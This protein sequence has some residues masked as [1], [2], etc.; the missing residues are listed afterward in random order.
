MEKMKVKPKDQMNQ[1]H[2]LE[3]INPHTAGIDIGSQFHYVCVGAD[4]DAQPIRKF[5]CFT[6]ELHKLADWL[7]A[8]KITTVAMESTGVYWIPVFQ[9]L[10][11][12]GLHVILVNARHVKNV[13]GKKTD[14]KDC[15][16]LQQLHSYGLLSGSFRPNADI[17]VLRSYVR[18]RENLIRN[19]AAH[20][21]R[22]QKA[23]TQMNLQLHKVISDITGATGIAIIKAI[24]DGERDPKVLASLKN[25]QIK[26]DEEVIANALV[27][28]Y[29]EE[30]LFSLKQEYD[31][32]CFY[33]L[34]ITECD[35]QI[36]SF[37]QNATAKIDLTEKPLAKRKSKGRTSHPKFDLRQE[38]YRIIGTD[39]TA[40]PGFDV[41][42]VQSIVSEV[43]LDMTKWPTEK[44]FASWLGLSPGNKIS[45]DKV[46][47]SKTRKVI[48]RATV[49]FRM[50]AYAAG[51][52]HTALGAYYRRLKSR[53][54][55]PKAITATA[56]KLACLC[57]RL[58][59]F[60]NAYIE[61]GIDYYE[62]RYK[63]RVIK[64]LTNRAKELGYK[65][66]ENTT[67]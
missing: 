62:T 50:A 59:R 30:H 9:V 4:K 37:Y 58:L 3:M 25:K 18:Q 46:L 57:Y 2:K 13:P 49:A 5:E 63:E 66:V 53:L 35:N 20:I 32:Y 23:L 42:T 29:R 45:G 17:C 52:S 28:D 40:I 55:A 34:K 1:P 43:G 24:L 22:M 47:S 14:V 15:Q 41:L 11:Q 33:Q 10:E 16:W 56:R 48:N 44:H 8:C 7:I 65:L 36:L 31:L 61:Q 67:G 51:K 27:G 64:N 6:S 38:L 39:V 54:G 19:A 60:G 21:Q 26:N 12:R